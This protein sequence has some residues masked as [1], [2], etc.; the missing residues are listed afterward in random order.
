MLGGKL[1]IDYDSDMVE[2]AHGF[3]T[4]FRMDSINLKKITVQN[5]LLL[6]MAI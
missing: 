6:Y 3:F 1:V 5:Q 2:D 4:N